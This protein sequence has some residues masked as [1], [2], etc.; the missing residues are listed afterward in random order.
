MSKASRPGAITACIGLAV[1]LLTFFVLIPASDHKSA[2]LAERFRQ[3][4]ACRSTVSGDCVLALP[5]Q[6]VKAW[7]EYRVKVSDEYYDTIRWQGRTHDVRFDSQDETNQLARIGTVTVKLWNGGLAEL[8]ANGK[9]HVPSD[10]TE[11]DFG[12]SF[13]FAI[14]GFILGPLLLLCGLGWYF[15]ERD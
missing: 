7:V 8:N 4:P 6:V 2:Q 12:E 10:S 11:Y 14:V 3:A 13:G 15:M 9:R 1:S 5:G